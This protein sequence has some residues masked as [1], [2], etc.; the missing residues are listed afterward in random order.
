MREIRQIK[1]LDY[2][3]SLTVDDALVNPWTL[4]FKKNYKNLDAKT[5]VE[6]QEN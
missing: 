2:G 5:K 1:D 6:L 4:R 3:K